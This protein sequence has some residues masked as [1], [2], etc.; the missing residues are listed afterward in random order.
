M[1]ENEKCFFSTYYISNGIFNGFYLPFSDLYKKKGKI[2][3]E[4][5]KFYLPYE[6]EFAVVVIDDF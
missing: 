2:P 4:K 3:Q 5:I 6:Y 1:Y